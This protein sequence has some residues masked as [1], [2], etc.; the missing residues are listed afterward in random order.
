MQAG[1]YAIAGHNAADARQVASSNGGP[2]VASS[3]LYEQLNLVLPRIQKRPTLANPPPPILPTILR[4]TLYELGASAIFDISGPTTETETVLAAGS[5]FI[6]R[7]FCCHVFAD[8][9]YYGVATL[10]L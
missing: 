8:L 3:R 7:H 9:V 6:I 2:L 1:W 5:T 4:Y 10:C